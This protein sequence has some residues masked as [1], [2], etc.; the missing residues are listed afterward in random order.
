MRMRRDEDSFYCKEKE[1]R[2]RWDWEEIEQRLRW[3]WDEDS[4]YCKRW[5]FFLLQKE[6]EDIEKRLRLRWEWEEIEQRLRWD[7]EKIEMRMRWGFFLLQVERE[8]IE[9]RMRWGF[10]LLQG[11]ISRTFSKDRIHTIRMEIA[12]KT[13][14]IINEFVHLTLFADPNKG[15]DIIQG[16]IHTTWNRRSV[17]L[18]LTFCRSCI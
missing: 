10:F 3:E 9:M 14:N 11:G 6:R 2:L 4:S 8:V 7:W 18:I 5:G 1:K 12:V 15:V 17:C 13:F 16:H